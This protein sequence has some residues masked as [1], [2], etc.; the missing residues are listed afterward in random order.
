MTVNHFD[1]T[2][3]LSLDIKY[4]QTL[5]HKKTQKNIPFYNACSLSLGPRTPPTIAHGSIKEKPSCLIRKDPVL[6]LLSIRKFKS[7][8]I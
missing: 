1:N 4:Q 3:Q 8:K 2:H 6:K 7:G 5:Q